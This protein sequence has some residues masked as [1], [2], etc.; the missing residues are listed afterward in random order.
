MTTSECRRQ[1]SGKKLTPRE[2]DLLTR[3]I[4]QGA[5]YA[6]HWSYVKPVRPPLPAVKRASAGRG[7]KSTISF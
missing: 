5:E 3:W 4:E 6:Q 7:T 1:A 2:I